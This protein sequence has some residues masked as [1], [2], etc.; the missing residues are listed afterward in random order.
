[1]KALFLLYSFTEL[2]DVDLILYACVLQWTSKEHLVP[3]SP[4]YNI[5]TYHPPPHGHIHALQRLVSSLLTC[6]HETRLFWETRL[7][8]KIKLFTSLGLTS[9]INLYFYPVCYIFWLRPAYE[10]LICLCNKSSYLHDKM[11]NLS[12]EKIKK[13]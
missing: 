12:L 11:G 10:G 1:M 2:L 13:H 9:I 7:M 6:T 3:Q 5:S 8:Q 4:P